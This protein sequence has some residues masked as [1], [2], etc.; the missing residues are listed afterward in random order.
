MI[1][2]TFEMQGHEK[3]KRKRDISHSC[4]V[5]HFLLNQFLI[6]FRRWTPKVLEFPTRTRRDPQLERARIDQVSIV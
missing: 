2:I 1:S 4:F 3:T 6:I 5:L